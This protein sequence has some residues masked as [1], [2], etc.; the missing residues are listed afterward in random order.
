MNY[1]AVDDE[2]FALE[3][4]EEALLETVPTCTLHGFTDPDKA[5][6]H[7]EN[8]PVDAAFLDIEMGR[9]S[10]LILAKQIKDIHPYAHI[11]FVTSHE[12]YAMQAFQ[13][14][15]IGYL[16]KPVTIDALRREL[17][18]LYGNLPEK[19]SVPA[20]AQKL[21]QVQTFGGFEVIANGRP[22]SFKRSKTKELLACLID[23]RGGSVTMSEA[24][25]ILWEDKSGSTTKKSY[26]RNLIT[27]LR[28]T[29]RNAG[30]E[31]VF[32][33][34]FNCLAIDPKQLDCDSY[35]F[36]EGDPQAVNK[37]QHDYL[38]GYSW[39]EFTVNS[40]DNHLR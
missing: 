27:D 26:L 30:A 24:C 21:L 25:A 15:A 6:R 5:L 3:D 22:L 16:M 10:G 23:R 29:L 34:R 14:H 37:Y 18:F 32:I 39:A 2:P 13:V 12:Q 38:P 11:I 35:R 40:L 20:P 8:H 36:M 17:T 33:K 4:L 7:A 9:T 1:I 19:S 31:A 28:T